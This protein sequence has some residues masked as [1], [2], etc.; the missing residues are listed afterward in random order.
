MDAIIANILRISVDFNF[1]ANRLAI[2]VR[3]KEQQRIMQL[4]RHPERFASYAWMTPDSFDILVGYVEEQIRKSD[5]YC[6]FSISP[7][8]RLL[9]TLRFLATGESLSSLHFQFQLG[10]STISGIVRHTYRALWDCLQEEFIP[11]PTRDTWL[12]IAD[13]FQQ[14]CQFP[15][16]LGAVDWKYIRI[17]KP[18]ASGSEF[19]NYKKYFSILLI[20]ITDAHYKF[21]AVDIGAYGHSNDSQVFKMSVM[22]RQLYGNT[23]DFPAERPLPDTTGPPMPFVFV[24]DEAFQLSEHLLKPYSSSG[25][26]QTKKVFNYRLSRAR[27][28]VECSFGI[29]TAKWQVLLTAINLKTETVDEVIKACVVLH[30][31]V[32]SKESINVDENAEQSTLRDYTNVSVRRSVPVCRLRDKFAD[33]FMSPEGRLEWQDDII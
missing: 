10:V 31:F 5:T 23:L 7:A 21:V 8:E 18:V 12:Q 16:C 20:A 24:A 3:E 32:I 30:N 14:I 9:V 33:Y 11:Q 13:G 4:R 15:N 1:E 25:L 29:L 6:R 27:R 2:I 28:M 17:V 22:G 26:T 19:Y